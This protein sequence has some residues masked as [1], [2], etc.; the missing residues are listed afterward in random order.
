M[1]R[2]FLLLYRAYYGRRARGRLW[3]LL[4]V[5]LLVAL[6]GD[7]HPATAQPPDISGTWTDSGGGIWELKASGPG[8]NSLH[9]SWRGA[10]GPHAG[11]RGTFNG[12]LTQ[13]GG[14]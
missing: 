7:A 6:L 9:A 1:R 14:A 2:P 10:P 11:I 8:L 3:P 13:Q 12:T 4:G 5:V